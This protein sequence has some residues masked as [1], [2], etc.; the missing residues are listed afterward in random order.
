[1]HDD[2][3]LYADDTICVSENENAMNRLLA[4]IEQ[5]GAT[6]G[7]KLNKKKCEYIKF[8]EA[9]AVHFSDGTPVPLQHEVKHLGCKLNDKGDPTR[10]ISKR[11]QD[12]MA[13]LNK[14]HVLFYSTNN[15]TG[16]KNAG[17]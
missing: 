15:K 1:M 12:C 9:H 17:V 11:I 6:Y 4:E 14:L 16:R 13:T 10:E 2:E 3:I 7:L 8:G 5:L